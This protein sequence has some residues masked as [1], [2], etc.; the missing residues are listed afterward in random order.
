MARCQGGVNE[1]VYYDVQVHDTPVLLYKLQP[2][3]DAARRA[4]GKIH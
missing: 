1:T 4:P 3:H 2:G